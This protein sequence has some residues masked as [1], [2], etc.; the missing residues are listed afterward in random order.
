M[1]LLLLHDDATY[2]QI[3]AKLSVA[4][5]T[6]G[7]WKKRYLAQGLPGLKDAPRP[8]TSKKISARTE[9][10]ICSIVQEPPP[11]GRTHWSASLISRRTGVPERSVNMVLARNNLKP[12]LHRSFMVSNDPDF[13]EKAAE[14]LG[15]YLNPPQNAVVLCV[16]EKS[17]IQALDRMQPNL[18][19]VA[20]RPERYTFEYKR[21]G[22][23]NLFAAFNTKSGEVIGQCRATHKQDDFVDFLDSIAKQYRGRR[24]I[25]IILDNLGT[26]K[27]PRVREWLARHE[28][29]H[30]HFTPTYSSW[31]NQVEI[32]FSIISRQCIRRGVFHSV[33]ELVTRIK[34]FIKEYNKT[35]KPFRWTYDKRTSQV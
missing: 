3:E 35:A 12:H 8:G 15:L 30:F 10:R 2:V 7:Q 32:F 9:A 17:Q 23:T 4:S 25:H 29:W 22:I 1:I 11:V 13:E 24:E 33:P 16:D 20:G 19:L 26:H 6:I 28:N 21:N 14:I 34:R 5:R 31:I 18:P 27:A